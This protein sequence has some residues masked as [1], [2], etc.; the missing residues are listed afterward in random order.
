MP[1]YP[2]AWPTCPA[3]VARRGNHCPAH[4][5]YGR[6]ARRVRDSMYDRYNRDPDVKAFY[7]SSDWQRARRTKLATN[8]VCSRCDRAWA[9]HVH[10]IKPLKRCTIEQRLAQANLKSLCA[11][12]HNVEEAEAAR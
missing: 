2:C 6:V 9:Q 3:Y 12:C 11:P 8:P 1:T 5:Q 10:H 7:N 4:E